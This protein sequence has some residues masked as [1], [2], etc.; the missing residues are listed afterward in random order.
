[1]K[2]A[3]KFAPLVTVLLVLASGCSGSDGST[4]GVASLSGA[5]EDQSAAAPSDEVPQQTQEEALLA[6]AACMRENGVDMEDPIV[7]ADGNVQFQFRPGAG[8]DAE[9]FDRETVQAAREACADL[10][11]GVTFG[12]EPPDQTEIQD[13][14]LAYASCMRE[15]G[16]DMDDPDFSNVGPRSAQSGDGEQGTFQG[17]FGDI[18]PSDPDFIAANE[19]CSDILA[20]FG[21]GGGGPGGGG[22]VFRG[23]GPPPGDGDGSAPGDGTGGSGSAG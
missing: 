4:E 12:F 20:G 7:D 22:F 2:V 9:N 10:F 14:L 8:P 15:N 5:A 3:Y 19:V 18:D 13:N 11:A 21:P 1:M 17:P 6:Y 16:Y 23:G